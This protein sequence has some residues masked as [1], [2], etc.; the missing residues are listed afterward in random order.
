[1]KIN[2][3]ELKLQRK[4]KIVK[5]LQ[6]KDIEYLQKLKDSTLSEI[7][8]L[9]DILEVIEVYLQNTQ[10]QEN[11]YTTPLFLN[12]SEEKKRCQKKYKELTK[13]KSKKEQYSWFRF[14][15]QMIKNPF[16]RDYIRKE[17]NNI[18]SFCHEIMDGEKVSLHHTTYDYTCLKNMNSIDIEDGTKNSLVPDCES[19]FKN[20]RKKFDDCISKIDYVHQSCHSTIH[21]IEKK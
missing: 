15:T 14:S 5:Q 17:Q 19:C 16:I 6:D 10:E 18:C 12:G 7:E 1:M 3:Y 20:N 13:D 4:L 21:G 11:L 9:N 8:D 2:D